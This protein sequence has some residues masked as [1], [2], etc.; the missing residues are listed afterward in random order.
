MHFTREQTA[1][2]NVLIQFNLDSTLNGIKVHSTAAPAMV[3]AVKRL[4]HKGMVSSIDGGY[5]TSLGY[6]AAE[7]AQT[8]LVL[9]A[10]TDECA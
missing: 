8:L 10:S 7:H 9:L 2:I 1:E 3:N 4:F 5:L 6:R